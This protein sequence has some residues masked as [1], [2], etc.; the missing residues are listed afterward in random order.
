MRHP[1]PY[2]SACTALRRDT[3][4][5]T[6]AP[7]PGSST[8][9]Q[10]RALGVDARQAFPCPAGRTKEVAAGRPDRACATARGGPGFPFKTRHGRGDAPPFFARPRVG[11]AHDRIRAHP[12]RTAGP[13]VQGGRVSAVRLQKMGTGTCH[14]HPLLSQKTTY[15]RAAAGGRAGVQAARERGRRPAQGLEE[16]DVELFLWVEQTKQWRSECFCA[17][18]RTCFFVFRRRPPRSQLKTRAPAR[19]AQLSSS[20]APSSPVR[21]TPRPA[22]SP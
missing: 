15:V 10:A 18:E 11:S 2:S 5:A 8:H 13:G 1:P 4:Q 19:K 14:S 3:A 21:G 22:P 7:T 20:L 16:H 17:R 12:P 9:H 6:A